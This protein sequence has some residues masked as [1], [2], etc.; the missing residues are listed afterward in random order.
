MTIAETGDI[1]VVDDDDDVREI[2]RLQLE[3]EGFATRGASNGAEA[4]TEVERDRP[5]VVLLDMMM[6]VMSGP[7][8]VHAIR[9]DERWSKLPI[10]MVTAW[11]Q[12]ASGLA[13][14]EV[15]SKPLELQAL[16]DCV[17]RIV[18]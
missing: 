8:F 9:A 3:A 6:P 5:A 4:L 16:L 13:V 12:E 1:L 2:L 18:H 14:R 15:L 10:V 11:P 17:H 7:E